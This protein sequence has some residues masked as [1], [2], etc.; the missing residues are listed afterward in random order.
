MIRYFKELEK[1][2]DYYLDLINTRLY[3]KTNIDLKVLPLEFFEK[4]NYLFFKIENFDLLFENNDKRKKL[5]LNSDIDCSDI[6][7]EWAYSSFINGQGLDDMGLS[8][9]GIDKMNYFKREYS[10][11]YKG[12]NFVNDFEKYFMAIYYQFVYSDNGVNCSKNCIFNYLS[13]AKT[14]AKYQNKLSKDDEVLFNDALN[15]IK[16]YKIEIPHKNFEP[17]RIYLPNSWYITP[18]NHLYNT[19]GPDGHK[20]ANLIYPFYYSIIR[21]DEVCNP[22]ALLKSAKRSLEQGFIDKFTFDNYT[23]LMYDFSTIYP[24]SYYNLSDL[25]KYRYT[26][27]YR[28]TYNPRIV[29]LIAGINSAQAG[30]F[31]FFYHL[32]NNSCD[33]YSDLD[34]IKQFDLDEILVRCCGFH[35]ISS[36]CDKTITTSCI[37]YEEEFEEYIRKGW[38]IDFIKPII[39][40]PY[41][42]RVEEYSDEFLLIKKM[43]FNK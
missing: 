1:P 21:D 6:P 29:K 37:N 27:L 39:L 36:I 14:M 43:H 31:S 2:N 35:K 11:K 13:S 38:N 30:L 22:C 12:K 34:F 28:K 15:Y 9:N 25:E 26:S 33:Y 18:Y 17:I 3:G 24:E 5:Y 41:T 19:M 8:K 32:K 40:N 10:K 23:N 7:L 20:E 4:Y 16:N 42:K